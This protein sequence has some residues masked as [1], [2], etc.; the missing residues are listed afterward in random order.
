MTFSTEKSWLS[1]RISAHLHTVL[2]SRWMIS[3]IK[4]QQGSINQS[5]HFALIDWERC[6]VAAGSEL[7]YLADP[8]VVP[9]TVNKQQAGQETELGDRK[10]GTVGGLQIKKYRYVSK[11]SEHCCTLSSMIF[12]T[13]VTWRPSLPEIPTPTAAFWIIAT[14]LA[15]SP[16]ARDIA[17]VCSVT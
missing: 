5:E 4:V 6:T 3:R 17:F 15:P 1:S 11:S 12:F 16:M 10:V 7:V 14:S 2:T 9:G 8:G 13:H